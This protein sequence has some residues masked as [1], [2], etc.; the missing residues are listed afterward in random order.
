MV[1]ASPRVRSRRGA[2]AAPLRR[3]RGPVLDEGV[4]PVSTGSRSESFPGANLRS[5]MVA[6]MCRVQVIWRFSF[7]DRRCRPTSP[8]EASIGRF[9]FRSRSGYAPG[10]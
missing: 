6:V 9:R 7:R 3:S 4:M 5:S 2:Q 1:S 10:A 8:E